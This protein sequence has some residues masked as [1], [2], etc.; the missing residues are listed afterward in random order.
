MKT[1]LLKT[2]SILIAAILF[3]SNGFT[4]NSDSNAP[5][6]LSG[7]YTIGTSGSY[8][9]ITAAIADLEFRGVSDTVNFIL[10]DETYPSETFPLEITDYAGASATRPVTIKPADGI[11]A[12]I[13]GDATSVINLMSVSYFNID[14]SGTVGDGRNIIISNTNSTTSS[15]AIYYY[16]SPSVPS[17]NNSVQN[18]VIKTG[19]LQNN[20]NGIKV[21]ATGGGNNNFIIRNNL[22]GNTHNCIYLKGINSLNNVTNAVIE[23]NILGNDTLPLGKRGII[24]KHVPGITINNNTITGMTDG[25]SIAQQVGIMIE[26]HCQG[27]TMTISNN[28]IGNLKY[29]GIFSFSCIGIDYHSIQDGETIIFNNIIYDIQAPTRP[30]TYNTQGYHITSGIYLD[31][32]QNVK[33]YNNTISLDGECL[34][35]STEGNSANVV[36]N[37][38]FSGTIDMR[39]NI[40]H[41]NQTVDGTAVDENKTYAI[42]CYPDIS[43]FSNIDNNEYYVSGVNSQI[44]YYNSSDVATLNDWQTL[45]TQDDN[46]VSIEPFFESNYSLSS[47]KNCQLDN[48]GTPLP[49]VFFDI[50]GIIRD[51]TTPDIGAY[52]FD[53]ITPDALIVSDTSVCAEMPMPAFTA[54]PTG[55][56]HWYA[57]EAL[58][59]LLFIGDEF[60]SSETEAGTYNYY[61]ADVSGTCISPYTEVTLEINDCS[62]SDF[63]WLESFENSGDLPEIWSP[64]I[65][66]GQGGKSL[67]T[68]SESANS[69]SYAAFHDYT[70]SGNN[71][72]NWLV[73]PK[74]V[75]SNI[76]GTPMLS[77]FEK[78]N[79][80][81]Y[82]DYSGVW[83]SNGSGNPEDGDYLELCEASQ[84]NTNYEKTTI[85]LSDYEDQDIYIAFVYQGEYAHLWYVDDV[86]IFSAY[87][88]N[89]GI[90]N[91]NGTIEATVDGD[92]ITDGAQTEEGN[93]IVFTATPDANNEV[94]EWY[95][96]GS[97][98]SVTDAV[99]A[100]DNL[101]ENI[102][103]SVEFEEIPA[104]TY[105]V[106]FDLETGNGS[107]IAEVDGSQIFSGD[108]VEEGNDIVF[109]ATPDANN[110]VI[111]WYVNGSP[112]SV[113]D[114]VFTYENLQENINVSVEFEE[115]PAVTYT[116]T[117]D[118]ETGNGSLIAEV[119]GS[120]IF[121]G[122]D[123][124]E[125]NDIVFTAT[126][127]ANNEVI[128]WYVNGSPQSVTDE[129]FTYDNLQEDINVTVEFEEIPAVTYT[130]IFGLEIGNGSLIAEVSGSQ[131]FSGDDVVEGKDIVFTATPDAN[132]EV[133]EWY[134]NGSPQSVTD[135][136]FTYENL[137]EDINVTVE[138]DLIQ[139]ILENNN[140]GFSI[141]PNPTTGIINL[142]VCEALVS[143]KNI[144]ITDITGKTIKNFPI[145]SFSNFQINI[146]H[147]QNG[148]YLL[149]VETET[150]VYIQKIIKQ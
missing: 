131:I 61:V 132:N 149:K 4:Q 111:E 29:N 122:D 12:T 80:A 52:E 85:S 6:T 24:A 141:Y 21:D 147:L 146:S 5:A 14:G 70:E 41:N 18:C 142:T 15:S 115:I 125:G 56:A 22:I 108:D 53:A 67:W 88:V 128:E 51:V 23:D 139:N 121:S 50:A 16:N 49:E 84:T 99:F 97:P 118:L 78:M 101:Q 82:Y 27:S 7:D 38:N 20:N 10:I 102:N 138:F 77:F 76:Q 89:M 136:V 86:Y 13:E 36:V 120:Q 110:E 74:L 116:V 1:Q 92:D 100:Y 48:L 109:T 107:L 2:I 3:T 75:L 17:S 72:N 96:N 46:S 123:V 32:A 35:P 73:S 9:T 90:E 103:V 93:D 45:T 8:P 150:R 30:A 95:V 140:N 65:L 43:V 60:I 25:N 40:L 135:E 42:V 37:G 94:I 39:N 113:T 54:N 105:T 127:D 124:E 31:D 114:E 59:D 126:P 98:Q 91:G 145:D 58:T 28:R 69:G 55:E 33:L 119:D 137:Q 79:D 11:V 62:V 143:V 63:S 26:G 106:T 19:S 44:A 130:V 129:V 34:S 66:D 57:D 83:I 134:V 81:T 47:E 148:V 64:F 133:I 117:F 112:Q 71:A 144:E 87:T 68:T 104:V